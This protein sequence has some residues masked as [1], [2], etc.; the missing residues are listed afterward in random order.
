MITTFEP[1]PSAITPAIRSAKDER[2]V[3][4]DDAPMSTPPILLVDDNEQMLRGMSQLLQTKR[5]VVV[6]RNAAEGLDALANHSPFSVVISDQQMPG[7]SGVSFLA[8]VRQ[9]APE[10]VR[11]MCTGVPD[12]DAAINSINSGEVF[13]FL[14]KPLQ[15]AVFERAVTAAE[16][17]YRMVTGQRI[18]LSETLHG[19][20]KVLIDLLALTSPETF[21]HATRVKTLASKLAQEMEFETTWELEIAAMLAFV[22]L[23]ALPHDVTASFL[24]MRPLTDREQTL[25][26]EYPR[27]SLNILTNIPR[28]ENV[29][30]IIRF[31]SDEFRFQSDDDR[32]AA[33]APV[34]SQIIRVASDFDRLLV[35]GKSPHLALTWL[36]ESTDHDPVVVAALGRVISSGAP[37]TVKIPLADLC[38]GMVIAEDLHASNGRTLLLARGQQLTQFLIERLRSLDRASSMSSMAVVVAIE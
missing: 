5:R 28:M 27:H 37:T 7:Q 29:C 9:L 10:T 13:R 18:L 25:F 2:V 38:P 17:Q 22:G 35:S 12:L 33:K 19:S 16:A 20:I 31:H 1:S 32:S 36:Q 8:Q 24:A 3:T 21:G 15:P 34:A 30:E 4:L 6:A 23:L 11:I 26:L 14:L